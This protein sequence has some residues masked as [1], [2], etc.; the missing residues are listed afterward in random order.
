MPPR[1]IA[2]VVD[3]RSQKLDLAGG[4][5][6]IR[7]DKCECVSHKGARVQEL[8]VLGDVGV[9]DKLFLENCSIGF[10]SLV[11]A[12]WWLLVSVLKKIRHDG[13]HGGVEVDGSD[14]WRC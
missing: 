8:W 6:H 14:R 9:P 4:H 7:L 11:Y 5:V 13:D 10:V 3:H 2:S 1:Y 12:I